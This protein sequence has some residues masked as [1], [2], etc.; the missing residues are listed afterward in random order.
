MR[1]HHMA[2]KLENNF[3]SPRLEK[4]LHLFPDRLTPLGI[5]DPPYKFLG[6][7][8]LCSRVFRGGGISLAS[9][10]PRLASLSGDCSPDL[11]TQRNLSK[12]KLKSDCIYHFPNL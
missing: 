3:F 12:I 9:T 4:K 7:M 1:V 8:M 2:C 5:K 6:T 10:M 11:C